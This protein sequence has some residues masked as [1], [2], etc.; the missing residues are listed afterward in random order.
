VTPARGIVLVRPVETPE[1]LPGGRIVLTDKTR[2][3]WT[4]GQMEV[5]AIGQ[6]P[7]C[8]AWDDGCERQHSVKVMTRAPD[9]PRYHPCTIGLGDWV[10][11]R[12]RA[13]LETDQ[14]GLFACHQDDL[15]A[16]LNS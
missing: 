9:N 12:H 3:D 14:S 8:K 13:L 15:L 2:T 4:A 5:V 10:L 7:I 16:V 11:V 6:E 1:S